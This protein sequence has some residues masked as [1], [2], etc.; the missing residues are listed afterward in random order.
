MSKKVLIV[1]DDPDV[2]LFNTTVVE[3]SG[4]TP[5]EAANGE[6]GLKIIRKDPP[7]LVVLDVLMPKQSGI[8]LY[9][10]LKSDKTLM[11]IPVIILSGVAKRTFL[12]SQKALTEF[13]DKPVPEP[14]NYL[15]K[16]V[17]PDELAAEIKKFLG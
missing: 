9:R 11:K 13:G 12:R 2:R 8:R 5:V 6:E 14:E 3:E 7:D 4:H 17:E 15:E 1:D 16:P 10:E